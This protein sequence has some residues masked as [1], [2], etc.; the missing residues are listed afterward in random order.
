MNSFCITKTPIS[1]DDDVRIIIIKSDGSYKGVHF[2]GSVLNNEAFK[3]VGVPFK[4]CY[5][6]KMRFDVEDS[7]EFQFSLK[8]ANSLVDENFNTWIELESAIYDAKSQVVLNRFTKKQG[9]LSFFAIKESVYQYILSLDCCHYQIN[10]KKTH[11]FK[12]LEA[13]FLRV[14]DFKINIKKSDAFKKTKLLLSDEDDIVSDEKVV[15]FMNSNLANYYENSGVRFDFLLSRL[16]P[17]SL[18]DD[19][20]YNQAIKTLSELYYIENVLSEMG[21]FFLPIHCCNE[22]ININ[23]VSE[24]FINLHINNLKE[25]AITDEESIPF[26]IEMTTTVKLSSILSRMSEWGM[27]T[28]EINTHLIELEDF[29]EGAHSFNLTFDD[30]DFSQQSFF[31]LLRISLPYQIKTILFIRD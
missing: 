12:E 6:D 3:V 21:L 29:A 18:I 23:E 7:P 27:T 14:F 9:F 22:T 11:N 30:H 26:S 20:G 28:S 10:D 19:I 15:R 4:A 1:Y 31:S 2:E 17:L 24:F 8:E 16:T 13:E 25:D 5:I